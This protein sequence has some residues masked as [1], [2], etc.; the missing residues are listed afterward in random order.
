MLP[1]QYPAQNCSIA[2][3]LEIVG[4]RWTLLI[5]REA[6]RGVMRFDDLAASLGVAKNILA[7]RLARLTEEGILERRTYQDG[8]PRYDY[9]PSTKG[10]GLRPVLVAMIEWGDHYYA[11]QGAP[12]VVVHHGCGGHVTSTLACS[13]CGREVSSL[14]VATVPGPGARG[15]DEGRAQDR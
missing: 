3:T 1:R 5:V 10:H 7:D 13:G 12:R 2:R 11:P 4:D 9:V 6:L 8:P 14:D 15:G